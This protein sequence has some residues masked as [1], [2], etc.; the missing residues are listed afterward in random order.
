MTELDNFIKTRLFDNPISLPIRNYQN[1]ERG[2]LLSLDK[3]Q[4]ITEVSHSRYLIEDAEYWANNYSKKGWQHKSYFELKSDNLNESE[5]SYWADPNNPGFM[6]NALNK[7][8]GIAKSVEYKRLFA[9]VSRDNIKS[10]RLIQR[11]SF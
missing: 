11:C 2:L 4:E 7:L 5:V 6:T 10:Q 3:Y 9:L 1:N 8:I